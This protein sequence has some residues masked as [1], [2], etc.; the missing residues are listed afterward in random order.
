MKMKRVALALLLAAA[1]LYALA[2]WMAP[3]HLAWGYVAAFAEAAMVGAIADWFA[4]VALFRRPLGLP[5]PHTAIIPANKDRIGQRLAGFIV[6]HFLSTEQVTARLADFDAAGRLAAWL[7]DRDH[8]ERLAG[9]LSG[10]G[11]WVVQ[12]LD[13]PRVHPFVTE[14]ARSGLRQIDVA[15]LS[16]QLIEALMRERRHQVLLDGVLAQLARWLGEDAVQDA[17]SEAIA[18]EVRVL[19]R[20]GLDQVAARLATRKVVLMI[21]RSLLELAEDPQHRLRLAFDEQVAD[22]AER[23]QDDEA[24]R[25]RVLRLR[26]ELLQRPELAASVRGLWSE[27]LA[28]LQ[29]DLRAQDSWLR[30]RSAAGLQAL[31]QRL[32]ADRAVRAWINGEVRAAAP[33]L[34]ERHRD[35][36]AALI[37]ARVAGWN[38][39]ELSAELERHIGNDLQ[40]IRINGTLVGGLVGLLIHTVTAWAGG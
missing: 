25:A 12:A 21:A 1:A 2:T 32:A 10:V 31:G 14:L 4:V 15:R 7:A 20:V 39:G 19:R 17:I 6:T 37:E 13:D 5:I 33:R 26:D 36:I 8:A 29:A 24:L 18:R 34:L 22:W 9:R 35:A 30:Q 38:A 16:G 3:R 23:L 40:Y 28:W 11:G 27:L